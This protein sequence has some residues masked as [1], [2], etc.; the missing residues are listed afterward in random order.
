M[1]ACI[2]SLNQS[3]NCTYQKKT[4]R[5]QVQWMQQRY[6][7]TKHF[8]KHV[9]TKALAKQFKN[10]FPGSNSNIWMASL[11][12]FLV[13]P[14]DDS[15]KESNLIYMN[16]KKNIVRKNTMPNWNLESMIRVHTMYWEVK[17]QT[18][19]SVNKGKVSTPW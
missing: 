3:T 1:Y 2:R 15:I 19:K 4:K 17:E 5:D 18:T 6:N 13:I 11:Y 9:K 8:I 12:K 14:D 7:K 16:L 10:F